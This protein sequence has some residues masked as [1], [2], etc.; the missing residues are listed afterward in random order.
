MVGE[1]LCCF[2]QVSITKY[3]DFGP[4][5]G[6]NT[7]PL[8]KR[9]MSPPADLHS[10]KLIVRLLDRDEKTRENRPEMGFERYVKKK[11][12]ASN[13]VSIENELLFKLVVR[14]FKEFNAKPP[15]GKKFGKSSRQRLFEEWAE[16]V[17]ALG[18]ST[19]SPEQIQEKVR[20]AIERCRRSIMIESRRLN[21]LVDD[22]ALPLIELPYYLKPLRQA[23][24]TGDDGGGSSTVSNEEESDSF[25]VDVKPLPPSEESA[26]TVTSMLHTP[27]NSNSCDAASP[28]S[29][30]SPRVEP[31]PAQEEMHVSTI[32][33]FFAGPSTVPV[34]TVKKTNNET[35]PEADMRLSLMEAEIKAAQ[36][37]KA[38]YAKKMQ[39]VDAQLELTILQIQQQRKR[40]ASS[41][42]SNGK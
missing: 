8:L 14:N 6:R 33:P 28:A 18:I 31:Q 1:H 29:A 22:S 38:Y 40:A 3:N 34:E 26:I 4:P 39:L 41:D 2:K 9:N 27:S 30:R 23:L 5:S 24:L 36:M 10:H 25:F 42:L 37:K 32:S 35:D 17:T 15:P 21:G 11:V 12:K 13:M 16:Q 20:K 19:R 7:Y